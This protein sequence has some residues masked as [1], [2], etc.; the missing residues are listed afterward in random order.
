MIGE[1]VGWGRGLEQEP[2]EL[3]PAAPLGELVLVR[4]GQ[5]VPPGLP[6]GSARP[7]ALDSLWVVLMTDGMG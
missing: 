1:E 6:L 2:V 4:V 3:Q 5:P 7:V